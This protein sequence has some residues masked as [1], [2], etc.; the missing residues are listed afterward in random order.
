MQ[1]K[2]PFIYERN[3]ILFM[4]ITHTEYGDDLAKKL[5]VFYFVFT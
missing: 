4:E 5:S 2:E 1:D 3:E